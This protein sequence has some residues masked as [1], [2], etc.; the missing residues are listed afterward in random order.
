VS[1]HCLGN[2]YA[3]QKQMDRA[4]EYHTKSLEIKKRHLG[5]DDAQISYTL[6]MLAGDY[7][8]KRDYAKALEL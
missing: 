6:G 4:I 1:W 3:S 2:V 5:P 7:I 8:E